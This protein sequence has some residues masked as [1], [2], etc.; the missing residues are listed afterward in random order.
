LELR[1]VNQSEGE[2]K[3][4]QDNNNAEVGYVHPRS[5]YTNR[6]IIFDRDHLIDSK[7]NL[8]EMVTRSVARQL[9]DS[10][11]DILF[12]LNKVP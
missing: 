3:S 1:L 4:E 6:E 2:V 8:S 9:E 5:S 10:E 11:Q 12:K 7:P